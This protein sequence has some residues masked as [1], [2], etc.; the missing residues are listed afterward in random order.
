MEDDGSL[1]C[2][3][4]DVAAETR[5]FNCEVITQQ[6]LTNHFLKQNI[7]EEFYESIL[8]HTTKSN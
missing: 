3:E 1:S 7:K 8:Q 4:I 5:Q 2:L 6:K